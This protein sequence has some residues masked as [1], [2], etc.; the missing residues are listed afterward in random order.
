[1][2][3][4]H[5]ASTNVPGQYSAEQHDEWIQQKRYISLTSPE[6]TKTLATAG[7][8]DAWET[9]GKAVALPGEVA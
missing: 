6:Q 9:D 1:M 8:I 4:G 3:P 5:T 2:P 7:V